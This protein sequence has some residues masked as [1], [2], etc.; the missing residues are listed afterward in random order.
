[1]T[2]EKVRGAISSCKDCA[3]SQLAGRTFRI[4]DVT[5]RGLERRDSGDVSSESVQQAAPHECTT[6]AGHCLVVTPA[7]PA[8][9]GA[10]RGNDC[11]GRSRGYLALFSATLA[12]PWPSSG[13]RRASACAIQWSIGP[14]NEAL[15]MPALQGIR[16]GDLA[17]RLI[18]SIAA[19]LTG[20]SHPE[21]R[22]RTVALRSQADVL[23]IDTSLHGLPIGRGTR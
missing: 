9:N 8:R 17:V 20:S 23:V 14:G 6:P 19:S 11:R 1:M 4:G 2:R 12:M 5:F 15:L 7:R 21:R 10:D 13:M 18:C 16:A 22:T 3:L